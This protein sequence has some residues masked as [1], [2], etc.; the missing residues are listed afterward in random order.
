MDRLKRPTVLYAVASVVPF[1]LAVEALPTKL[2]HYVLPLYPLIALVTADLIEE[3]GIRRGITGWF[4]RFAA[5]GAALLPFALMIASIVIAFLLQESIPFAGVALLVVAIVVG[6]GSE[7]LFRVSVLSSA[8]LAILTAAITY[9][10]V[11]GLILPSLDKIRISERLVA[12]GRSN[13]VCPDPDFA[14]A[15]FDEPSL[16]LLGGTQTRL[17]DGERAATFLSQGACRVAFIE[18]RQLASFNSRADDL[19]LTPTTLGVVNGYNINGGRMLELSVF[20]SR[21][22][23]P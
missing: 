1:W 21:V 5:S 2:P 20:L 15:G 14:S 17:G 12:L 6:L 13:P 19:G 7:R 23:T 10:A 16:V 4:A 22:P 9:S 8:L 18:K 3:G 11:F